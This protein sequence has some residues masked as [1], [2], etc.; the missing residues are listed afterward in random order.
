MTTSNAKSLLPGFA[1]NQTEGLIPEMHLPTK[2]K[3]SKRT[4]ATETLRLINLRLGYYRKVLNNQSIKN[5]K[6]I[7]SIKAKYERDMKVRKLLNKAIK[8]L[9]N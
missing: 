1:V 4:F 7:K 5:E 9:Y 8:N 3:Y 2:P 6:R